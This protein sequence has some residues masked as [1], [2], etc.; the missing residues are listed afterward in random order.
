LSFEE[1]REI[2]RKYWHFQDFRTGQAKAIESVLTGRDTL[3]IMPTGG[4]KSL[5]YQVPAMLLPGVTIVISPLISLMKD[6]AGVVR[7]AWYSRL[8]F[9]SR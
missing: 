3:V 9:A 1:A 7:G 8:H 2:L 6:Q 5:C 4:G